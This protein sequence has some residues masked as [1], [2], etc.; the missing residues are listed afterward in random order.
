MKVNTDRTLDPEV[1]YLTA[2]VFLPAGALVTAMGGVTV[3]SQTQPRAFSSFSRLHKQQH[4]QEGAQKFQYSVQVGSKGLK[5]NTEW[6]IP[7]NNFPLLHRLLRLSW[8][9]KGQMIGYPRDWVSTHN[10]RAVKNT[11]MPTF[12]QYTCYMSLRN[13]RA[14][15][16]EKRSNHMM[17][18]W[19]SRQ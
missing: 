11:S 18:G 19:S 10:T 4:E 14:T 7:P 1:K 13:T 9:K 8:E 12:S 16:Q 5:G 2:K 17:N 15:A 6:L 3:Q